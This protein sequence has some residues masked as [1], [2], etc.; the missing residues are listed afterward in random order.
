MALCLHGFIDGNT[1]AEYSPES[2]ARMYT[3]NHEG[4]SGAVTDYQGEAFNALPRERLV[5]LLL[6]HQQGLEHFMQW[7]TVLPVKFGTLLDG[8]GELLRLMSSEYARLKEVLSATKG[9]IEMEVAATWDTRRLLNEMSRDERVARQRDAIA[10]KSQ[11][12][13][14]DRV[15]LGQVVKAALDQRREN[16]RDEMLRFLKPLSDSVAFNPLVS[17]EMVL[18]VA[19][20]IQRDRQHDFDSRMQ[21]LDLRFQ[22][23]INFRVIGPLPPYNFSSI[24]I[25][26]LTWEEV[27]ESQRLLELPGTIS[28]D[29]VRRAY[30]RRAAR[31]QQSPSSSQKNTPETLVR[32]KKASDLLLEYCEV[33]HHGPP[34][35]E[36]PELLSLS[37][38][39]PKGEEIDPSRFGC[40][41]KV[42]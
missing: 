37:V 15:L 19:F 41:Q 23:E 31:M 38:R 27:H 4:L 26:H 2:G 17:D 6:S 21:E 32:L 9:H 42:C 25:V 28:P 33:R 14:A 30:R 24:E 20:L 10:A 7:H 3:I 12:T 16:Y 34:A 1:T 35:Q 5:R 40:Y 8:P 13:V 29:E 11:V 22:N 36:S 18:N 39:G